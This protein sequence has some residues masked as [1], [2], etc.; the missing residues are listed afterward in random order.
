MANYKV[1]MISPSVTFKTYIGWISFCY[2]E[3]GI[4]NL[5]VGYSSK[6][7]AVEALRRSSARDGH[8]TRP[9]NQPHELKELIQSYFEGE[10]VTFESIPIDPPRLTPFR[11]DVLATCRRIRYGETVSYGELA[12]RSGSPKAARAVGNIMKTNRLPLIIPCH[13]VVASGGRIGGFS[14]PSGVQLKQKLLD[15]EAKLV[16]A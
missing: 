7:E 5:T 4:Q 15:L 14:A 11:T 10:F 1:D 3:N 6:S 9:T 8:S 2:S 12:A 16:N 13:R